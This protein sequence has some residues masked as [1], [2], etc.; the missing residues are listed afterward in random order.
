MIAAFQDRAHQTRELGIGAN[1][2]KGPRPHLVHSFDLRDELDR[3][4]KLLRQE[5]ACEGGVVGIW[6]PCGIREDGYATGL[7]IDLLQGLSK[8]EPGLSHEPTMECRRYSQWARCDPTFGEQLRRTVDL[9]P[10]PRENTLPRCVLVS[11]HKIE[12]MLSDEAGQLLE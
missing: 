7:E 11:D 9:R 10:R 3:S 8:R 12:V 6:A 1:F 2:E 5:I 4:T